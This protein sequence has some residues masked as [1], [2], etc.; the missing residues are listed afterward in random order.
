MEFVL[1]VENDEPANVET[2]LL[3]RGYQVSSASDARNEPDIVRSSDTIDLLLTD[4]VM[5]GGTNGR[6][7][8][9][10]SNE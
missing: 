5:P 9:K 8:S 2:L 6:T 1:V 7:G 3:N 10:P 4:V